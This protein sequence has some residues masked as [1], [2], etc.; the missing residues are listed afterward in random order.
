MLIS[1]AQT[2]ENFKIHAQKPLLGRVRWIKVYNRQDKEN[3]ARWLWRG[4][5]D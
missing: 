3:P 1:I 4:L 5:E 2:R